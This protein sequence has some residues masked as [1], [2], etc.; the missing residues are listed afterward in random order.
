MGEHTFILDVGFFFVELKHLPNQKD[1]F[2]YH[3]VDSSLFFPGVNW[4]QSF[5]PKSIQH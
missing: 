1:Y 5:R 2:I 4:K 3:F